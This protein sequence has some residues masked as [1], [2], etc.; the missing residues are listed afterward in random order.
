MCKGL[1]QKSQNFESFSPQVPW[2]DVT[3]LPSKLFTFIF[4]QKIYLKYTYTKLL[5][6]LAIPV[7]YQ[8]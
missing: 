4:R 3:G 1:S 7:P 6:L 5:G 8:L 2:L